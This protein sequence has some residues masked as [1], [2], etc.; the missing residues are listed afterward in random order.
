MRERQRAA[1][2]RQ[3]QVHRLDPRRE[4]LAER[5]EGFEI[6]VGPYPELEQKQPRLA[7]RLQ[8]TGNGHAVEAAAIFAPLPRIDPGPHRLLRL[9]QMLPRPDREMVAD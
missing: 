5:D 1:D 7:H 9:D 3:A 6:G 4:F 2:P 8:E